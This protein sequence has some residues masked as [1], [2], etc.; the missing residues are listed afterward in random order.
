MFAPP[1]IPGKATAVAAITLAGSAA[2]PKTSFT[3]NWPERRKGR[4]VM[5]T[6]GVAPREAQTDGSSERG[7]GAARPAVPRAPV[8]AQSR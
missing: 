4:P 8:E 1:T 3:M 7:G 2:P 5:P 6:G